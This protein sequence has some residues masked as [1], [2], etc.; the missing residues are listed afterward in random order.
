MGKVV[1]LQASG[2]SNLSSYAKSARIKAF[3]SYAQEFHRTALKAGPLL[4]RAYL[5][6]HAIELYL[7]T[8]LLCE[9]TGERKLIGL[10][11]NLVRT[12]EAC[13]K[14]GISSL[15]RI[16][17]QL[18]NEL[19][20]FNKPYSSKALEYFSAYHFLVPPS[21]PPLQRLFR[22]ANTLGQVVRSRMQT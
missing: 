8:F 11:H 6:G 13:E 10:R 18:R 20:S 14:Q 2:I 5:L 21:L 12:L 16:S 19:V 1:E 9:G 22:F 3:C 7:K 17:D 4:V 15:L